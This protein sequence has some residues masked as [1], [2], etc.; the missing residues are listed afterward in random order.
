[1]GMCCTSN[2]INQKVLINLNDLTKKP[3][4]SINNDINIQNNDDCSILISS[5]SLEQNYNVKYRESTTLQMFEKTQNA[6]KK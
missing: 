3:P 4:N 2:L 6:N 5:S 1:M